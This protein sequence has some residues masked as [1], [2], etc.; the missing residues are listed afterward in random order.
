MVSCHTSAVSMIASA[1]LSLGRIFRVFGIVF[2]EKA[3]I[4][5]KRL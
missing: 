2:M 1:E 4:I 3:S 5:V